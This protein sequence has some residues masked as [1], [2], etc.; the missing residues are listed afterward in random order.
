MKIKPRTLPRDFLDVLI[1]L[2]TGLLQIAVLLIAPS[3]V[4]ALVLHNLLAGAVAYVL[5]YA[6][7]LMFMV[8]SITVDTEGIRFQRMLGSPKRLS[9]S[10]I[11]S[12]EEVTRREVVLHGW[13]WPL[14]PAREMTPAL[15]AKH[16]FRISWGEGFC[17][18]P[19][20]D[21]EQFKN[22]I[23]EVMKEPQPFESTWLNQKEN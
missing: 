6:V 23:S 12:V 14:L 9:R 18:F 20:K 3:A 22:A 1:G 13:L 19:P 17:Y 2:P 8:R 7:W 10:S 15:S 4:I 21:V 5:I 11:L 16:H